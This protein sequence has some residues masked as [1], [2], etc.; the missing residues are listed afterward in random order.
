[1]EIDGKL[2]KSPKHSEVYWVYDGKRHHIANMDA[3]YKYFVSWDDITST[4][5][6]VING[7]KSGSDLDDSGKFIR[8]NGVIQ[9]VDHDV[10]DLTQ[11][12]L[13]KLRYNF[14]ALDKVL[15]GRLLKLVDESTVYWVYGDLLHAVPS[16]KVFKEYFKTWDDV[17]VVSEVQLRSLSRGSNLVG[18]GRF[19]I[20]GD[21]VILVDGPNSY[22]LTSF[23]TDVLRYNLP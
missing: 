20:G 11:P 14:S 8:N 23:Y 6:D 4:T 2:L 5:D 13:D 1:M 7:I 17:Q 15:E 16:M 9:L 18:N 10:F 22:P 19:V 21:N 12:Y 3:F